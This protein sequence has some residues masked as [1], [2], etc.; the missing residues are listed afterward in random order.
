MPR[1]ATLKQLVRPSGA[2]LLSA[3]IPAA[4]SFVALTLA[5]THANTLSGGGWGVVGLLL[6][7]GA[8]AV[9]GMLL[10]TNVL[11][12]LCGWALGLTG[13]LAVALTAATIGSPLG[14]LIGKRLAGPGTMRVI[15]ENPKGAAV[16]EAIARSSSARAFVLVA[17]LRLSP[18]VPYGSTNVLAAVFDVR[19]PPLVLGTLLGLAPRAGAMV[20]LGAGMEQLDSETPVA[21]WVWIIGGLATVAALILM[22][23]AAKRALNKVAAEAVSASEPTVS[24]A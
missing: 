9:G 7:G 12:L 2:L 19:L 10:P 18:V 13:G 5:I 20:L 11:S 1:L 15:G 24:Q 22:S 14:Y 3:A 23:W 21:L 6:F 4:G 17:L 16:C 8:L